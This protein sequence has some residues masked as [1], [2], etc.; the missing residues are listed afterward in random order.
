MVTA[1][2]TSSTRE[3][4]RVSHRVWLAAQRTKLTGRERTARKRRRRGVRVEREVRPHSTGP[5]SSLDY[6]IGASQHRGWNGDPE[7]SRRVRINDKLERGRL[8]D[9]QIA[10]IGTL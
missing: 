8:L 7:C 1:D 3:G 4:A 2:D 5:V 10:W 9:R 6:S